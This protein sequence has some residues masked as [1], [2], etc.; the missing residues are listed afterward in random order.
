MQLRRCISGRFPPWVWF[1]LMAASTQRS[2]PTT[3][4]KQSDVFMMRPTLLRRTCTLLRREYILFNFD[5][6]YVISQE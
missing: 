4:D 1:I 3:R 2:K 6:C 5:L